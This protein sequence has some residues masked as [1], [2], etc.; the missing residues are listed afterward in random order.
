M[1]NCNCFHQW[2]QSNFQLPMLPKAKSLPYGCS[3]TCHIICNSSSLL[4]AWNL[5][6]W[7][8]LTNCGDPSS[9]ERTKWQS[10]CFVL[11]QK[12]RQNGVSR[13]TL[14]SQHPSTLHCFF[15]L[16]SGWKKLRL[17]CWKPLHLWLC[18]IWLEDKVKRRWGVREVW[19]HPTPITAWINPARSEEKIS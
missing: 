10:L 18:S 1:L 11:S 4:P 3:E 19:G 5:C 8:Q 2:V 17:R 7:D 13:S 15:F 14:S 6:C 9:E 16:A 12:Q